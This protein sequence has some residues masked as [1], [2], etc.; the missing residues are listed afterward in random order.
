MSRR[1]AALD[2]LGSERWQ[3]RVPAQS[4]P[5]AEPVDTAAPPAPAGDDSW[6]RLVAD[7]AA[8]TAC[9]LHR[10]RTQTVFGVGNRAAG[11]LEIGAAPGAEEDRRGEAFVG[12]AGELLKE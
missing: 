2:L 1:D 8:C 6:D 11:W 10:L 5:S 4:P 7:V 12:S 9:D 3:L